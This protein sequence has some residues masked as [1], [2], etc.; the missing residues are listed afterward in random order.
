MKKRCEM[1]ENNIGKRGKGEWEG[2][3]VFDLE[4]MKKRGRKKEKSKKAKMQKRKKRGRKQGKKEKRKKE[5]IGENTSQ[6]LS[7]KVLSIL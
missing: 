1:I 2:Y 5:G 3:R 6:W 7:D 4:K